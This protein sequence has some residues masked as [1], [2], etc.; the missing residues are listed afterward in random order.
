[1]RSSCEVKVQKQEMVPTDTV[2][3]CRYEERL[4]RFLL[5]QLPSEPVYHPVLRRQVHLCSQQC[6]DCA[7]LPRYYQR[8]DLLSEPRAMRRIFLS[9]S[10]LRDSAF[11]CRKRAA[12]RHFSGLGHVPVHLPP[13]PVRSGTALFHAGTAK[14]LLLFLL[15]LLVVSCPS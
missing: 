1:M 13:Q 14:F 15:L 9:V 5:S 8:S 4:L 10:R 6:C 12:E 2:R 11:V 3:G 7:L